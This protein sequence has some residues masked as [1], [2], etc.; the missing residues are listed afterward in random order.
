MPNTVVVSEKDKGKGKVPATEVGVSAAE[1]GTVSV[2]STPEGAD[3]SSDGNFMGN[4]PASLKLSPG[5]HT[6][7][8]SMAGHNDWTREITVSAGSELQLNAVLEKQ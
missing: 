6:V 7:K 1:T 8:V 3:V 2:K 4:A 5:K